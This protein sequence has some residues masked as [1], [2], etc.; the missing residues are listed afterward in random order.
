MLAIVFGGNLDAP[1]SNFLG[2]DSPNNWFGF[3]N[4][5]GKFGGFRFVA[6][7]SEHTLLTALLNQ[8]RVGLA[9]GSMTQIDGDWTAGNPI[10]GGGAAAF[11]KSSPQY[12]WM[13]MCENAEFRIRLADHIQRGFFNNGP[14]STTG[15]RQILLTRSNEIYRAMVCE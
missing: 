2:N 4:R 3:R 12:V 10:T 9:A 13:R 1:I 7:D 14:F 6:H 11:L 15:A 5:T 8:D